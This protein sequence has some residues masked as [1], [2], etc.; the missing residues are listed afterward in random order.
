VI[1]G[2]AATENTIHVPL[3]N[4]HVAIPNGIA[5]IS[6]DI[7]NNV[8]EKLHIAEKFGSQLDRTTDVSGKPQLILFESFV[9]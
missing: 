9:F 8:N 1:H 4:N 3:S 2:T 5:E 6:K 7:K